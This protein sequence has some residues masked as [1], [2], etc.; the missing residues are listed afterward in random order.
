MA[1]SFFKFCNV[2]LRDKAKVD[3]ILCRYFAVTSPDMLV[4]RRHLPAVA[5]STRS[6]THPILSHTEQPKKKRTPKRTAHGVGLLLDNHGLGVA[7]LHMAELQ[8]AGC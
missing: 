3:H 7:G 1:T 2:V 6:H 8:L 4:H 5:A